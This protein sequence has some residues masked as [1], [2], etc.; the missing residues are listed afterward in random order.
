MIISTGEGHNFYRIQGDHHTT[1][2]KTLICVILPM[3]VIFLW[4]NLELAT[5]KMKNV[6]TLEVHIYYIN[7]EYL[8]NIMIITYKI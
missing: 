2:L 1:W 8:W 5:K 4:A 7:P 3:L 6:A